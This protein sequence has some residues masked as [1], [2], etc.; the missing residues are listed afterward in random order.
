MEKKHLLSYLSVSDPGIIRTLSNVGMILNTVKL[1]GYKKSWSFFISL[2]LI[3]VILL[4][5]IVSS[6]IWSIKW[7]NDIE[8]AGIR[9]KNKEGNGRKFEMVIVCHKYVS[10]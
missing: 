7:L 4:S 9:K 3:A 5:M 2:A 1:Y 8:W 10:K 6:K